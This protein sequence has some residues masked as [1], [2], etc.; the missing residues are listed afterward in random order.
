MNLP[1]GLINHHY[2]FFTDDHVA[3][4][5]CLNSRQVIEFKDFSPDLISTLNKEFD[6]FPEKRA[7]ARAMGATN[8]TEELERLLICNYGGF[9]NAADMVDGKLQPTEF[10]AC[11]NRGKCKFEGIVCDKLKTASGEFLTPQEI[12]VVKLIAAGHLDKHIADRLAISV[13][14]VTTHTRNIRRKTKL[15]R[16]PEITRFAIQ[17]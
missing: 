12:Q 13:K 16:K 15:F 17:K 8:R 2:E 10:W 4:G 11:P 9:D 14:T 6:R 5:Y 1:A 3:H 7:G